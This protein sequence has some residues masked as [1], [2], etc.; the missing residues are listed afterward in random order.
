LVIGGVE[1]FNEFSVRRGQHQRIVGVINWP[2]RSQMDYEE[3][4]QE[5]EKPEHHNDARY[6]GA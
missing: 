2:D 4:R 5:E 3:S 1:C 6:A